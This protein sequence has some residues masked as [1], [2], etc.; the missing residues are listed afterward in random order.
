MNAQL[1]RLYHH[2]EWADNLLLDAIEKTG[3]PSEQVLRLLSHLFSAEKLWLM[4]IRH[5]D[6]S[7][8]SVWT[9]LSLSQCRTMAEE[10]QAGFREIMQTSTESQLAALISY[11]NIKGQPMESSLQDILFQ[12]ALHGSYHRGQ[13]AA[14]LRKEGLEPVGTD[15]ITFTR[16]HG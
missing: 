1:N 10:A 6:T 3:G 11:R 12:V 13:I 7:G 16:I 15:F 14:L 9:P 5:E 4:R 2:L 8:K